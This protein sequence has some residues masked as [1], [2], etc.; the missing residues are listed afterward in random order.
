MMKHRVFLIVFSL[1]MVVF[2]MIDLKNAIQNGAP[3]VINNDVLDRLKNYATIPGSFLSSLVILVIY[4][5]VHS[6]D[7]YVMESIALL[8]SSALYGWIVSIIFSRTISKRDGIMS[9][10]GH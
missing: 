7:Y 4:Q 5:N 3:F 2:V 10:G 1:L 9:N 6:Y 8:S